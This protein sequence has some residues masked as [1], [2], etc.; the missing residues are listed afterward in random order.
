VY[1]RQRFP[2]VRGTRGTEENLGC[3]KIARVPRAHTAVPAGSMKLAAVESDAQLRSRCLASS[4]VAIPTFIAH[5]PA[6]LS[7][8]SMA[9][10]AGDFSE[11]KSLR[12]KPLV[13]HRVTVVPEK[14]RVVGVA[15]VYTYAT[16]LIAPNICSLL[17][18][19]Q[20]V[21]RPATGLEL[22]PR[23]G[24]D[25]TLLHVVQTG[26]GAPSASYSTDTGS[27]SGL[28]VK[29]ATCLHVVPRSRI[30]RHIHSF[31]PYFFMLRCLI[32]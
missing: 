18:V 8:H 6:L 25:L 13:S 17:G 10:T 27:K 16:L 11:P 26:T 12:L 21:E 3:R 2:H 32:S 15:A 5:F 28:S 31:P 20:S 14:K 22:Q 7:P 1:E 19:A 30:R 9:R 23:S 29:L 24:Q 4:A